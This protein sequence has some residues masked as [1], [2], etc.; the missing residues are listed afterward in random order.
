MENAMT[1]KRLN[2]LEL[3]TCRL[4]AAIVHVEET[5]HKHQET[6]GEGQG[7]EQHPETTLTAG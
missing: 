3:E 4:A 1:K 7:Q 5:L 6:G 2:S